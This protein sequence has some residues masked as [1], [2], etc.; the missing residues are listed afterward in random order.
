[1]IYRY[2]DEFKLI[3]MVEKN[4]IDLV[5]LKIGRGKKWTTFLE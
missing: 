5:R 1:M 4:I 2:N 3:K